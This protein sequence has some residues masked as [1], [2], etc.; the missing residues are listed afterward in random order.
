MGHHPPWTNRL[1][2]EA[3]QPSITWREY[4]SALAAVAE[5]GD[6]SGAPGTAVPLGGRDRETKSARPA[7]AG[8][9]GPRPRD[10]ASHRL[11]GLAHLAAGRDPAAARHLDIAY[12]RVR[13]EARRAVGLGDALRL[14][15]E[16]AV[17]RLALVGLYARLG[18][19]S[20]A[21]SIARETQA[22]L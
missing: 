19:A 5:V 18:R 21:A 12:R 9:P 7:L 2:F 13:R 22:F 3:P 16:G 11:L 1:T 8:P 14:Q 17:L 10:E 6:T 20:R 4:C 15:Y